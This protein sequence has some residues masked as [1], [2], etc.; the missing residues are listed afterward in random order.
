MRWLSCDFPAGVGPKE[1]VGKAGMWAFVES[2]GF[3]PEEAGTRAWSVYS[4]NNQAWEEQT[5]VVAEALG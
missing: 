3:G 2:T 4:Y 5:G 1:Q